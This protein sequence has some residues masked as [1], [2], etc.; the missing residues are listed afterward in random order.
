MS[1]RDTSGPAFPFE[2]H[3][4]TSTP[5]PAF[6]QDGFINPGGAQQ[7]AGMTL[8]DWFAGQALAGWL[9]SFG[10][11]ESAKADAIARFSYEVADAMLEASK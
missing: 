8:R 6:F 3:N 9:S 10:P 11:T 2:Y 4:Q 5:Q 7:F 1:E